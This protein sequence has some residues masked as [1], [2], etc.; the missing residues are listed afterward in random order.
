MYSFWY[1]AKAISF[2]VWS[3]PVSHFHRLAC[4]KYPRVQRVGIVGLL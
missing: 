3:I 2:T 4:G 1:D